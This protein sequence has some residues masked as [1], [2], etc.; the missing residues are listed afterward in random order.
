LD[1]HAVAS[2]AH[3]ADRADVLVAGEDVALDEPEADALEPIEPGEERFASF[4]RPRHGVV[5]RNMTH[6]LGRDQ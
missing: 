4:D 3:R 6:D 2:G 1:I 5:T